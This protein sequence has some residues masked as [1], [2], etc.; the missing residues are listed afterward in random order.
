MFLR[1]IIAQTSV[2]ATFTA[3]ADFNRLHNIDIACS[4]SPA[5]MSGSLGI[6]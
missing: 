2:P 1:V 3:T 5:V 6:A 4:I